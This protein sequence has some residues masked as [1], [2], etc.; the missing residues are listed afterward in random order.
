MTLL[1]LSSLLVGE[2]TY[3]RPGLMEEVY[4]NR[5]DMGHVQPCP[6]CIGL[7]ALEGRANV[8]RR[9]YLTR[10]GHKPEGPFLVVDTGA[11]RTPGRVAEVDYRTARRWGMAGPLRGVRIF[12]LEVHR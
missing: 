5:L 2:V 6:N 12:T 4:R 8:G 10:P 7:I 1:L 3:Y 11:F 9:A